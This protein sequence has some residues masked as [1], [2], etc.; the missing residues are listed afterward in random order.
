[1]AQAGLTEHGENQPDKRLRQRDLHGIRDRETGDRY[2][3]K[4]ERK[5][6]ANKFLALSL[7]LACVG[8]GEI[9]C[10]IRP[11]LQYIGED[12]NVHKNA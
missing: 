8:G 6:R 5:N 4:K 10:I 11:V 2:E 7:Y 3:E 9:A 12:K 1:M